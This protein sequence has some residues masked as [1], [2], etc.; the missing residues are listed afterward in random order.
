M[1]QRFSL[2]GTHR[3]R[4]SIALMLALF[5]AI[6][7]LMLGVVDVGFMY[8]TKREYQKAA[9]LAAVAGA[10]ALA[11]PVTGTRSCNAATAAASSNAALN[12]R[13][14]AVPSDYSLA[15]S[16]GAWQP[17]DPNGPFIAGASE[18]ASSLTAV[19]ATVSG[20]PHGFFLPALAGREPPEISA[21]GTA[22]IQE[23]LASLRIRSTLIE[24]NTPADEANLIKGICVLLGQAQDCINVSGAGWQGVANAEVTLRDL[25][26]LEAEDRK[27]VV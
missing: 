15:I 26:E 13:G 10:Q 18:D 9:D 17:R 19:R 12:L 16:C 1:T 8:L 24:I 4:G 20:R 2:P 11:D 5:S 3:Q 6:M 27:S 23:A 7:V 14:A 25:V 21:Q 22:A